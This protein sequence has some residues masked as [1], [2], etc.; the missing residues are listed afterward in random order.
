MFEWNS[1]Y[2]CHNLSVMIFALRKKCGHYKVTNTTC[3]FFVHPAHNYHK[4]CDIPEPW[5]AWFWLVMIT[6]FNIN[7]FNFTW[8]VP[9]NWNEATW[10]AN[11]HPLLVI[12]Q[13]SL[14]SFKLFLSL[15]VVN[16][17]C[18]LWN[19]VLLQLFTLLCCQKVFIFLL[20][21]VICACS[22]LFVLMTFRRFLE[23][24]RFFTLKMYCTLWGIFI[25]P[26]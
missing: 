3:E 4:R 10:L 18:V 2:S 26:S 8:L 11:F 19:A 15:S 14:S 7:Y 25:G 24:N 23:Q 16:C 1:V 20:K 6:S 5:C 17:S 22:A 9:T 21:L 13:I 12:V